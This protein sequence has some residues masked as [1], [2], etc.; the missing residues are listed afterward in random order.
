VILLLRALSRAVAFVLLVVLAAGCLAAA[1]FS[2]PNRGLSRLGDLV[3]TGAGAGQSRDF[4][5]RLER[6]DPPAGA[7]AGAALAAAVGLVLVAGAVLPRRERMLEMA[8][9]DE[10]RLAARRRPLQS[11]ATALAL[12]PPG[13]RRARAR[14]RGRYRRRGGRLRVR[15]G[16]IPGAPEQPLAEQVRLEVDGLA[17]AFSLRTKV[18]TRRDERRRPR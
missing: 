11:V 4:L 12:R 9:E 3:G 5:A 2:L 6:G 13:V 17:R 14:I 16:R 7:A 15:V 10:G 18:R 1:G 8:D